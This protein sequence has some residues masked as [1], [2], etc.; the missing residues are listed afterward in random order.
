MAKTSQ[1]RQH[2]KRERSRKNRR[3]IDGGSETSRMNKLH[4]SARMGM[5]DYEA[6][7]VACMVSKPAGERSGFVYSSDHNG[8]I[9]KHCNGKLQRSQ[10]AEYDPKS[11]IVAYIEQLEERLDG[12]KS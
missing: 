8:W 11:D 1:R 2:A 4:G 9:C 12:E 10:G 7:C 6:T 3:T 5:H